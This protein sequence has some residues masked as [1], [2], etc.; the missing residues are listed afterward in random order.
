M[1]TVPTGAQIWVACEATDMRKGFDALSMLAQDVLKRNSLSEFCLSFAAGGPTVTSRP[2]IR[3]VFWNRLLL[4]RL[5]GSM[6][7]PYARRNPAKRASTTGVAHSTLN[8]GTDEI[9]P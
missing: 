1:I 5:T 6:G 3:T 8:G 7:A 4:D 9:H 2:A